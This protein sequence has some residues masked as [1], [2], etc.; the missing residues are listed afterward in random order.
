MD[1]IKGTHIIKGVDVDERGVV[2]NWI[3]FKWQDKDGY[4]WNHLAYH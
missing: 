3:L 1:R 4:T 2:E